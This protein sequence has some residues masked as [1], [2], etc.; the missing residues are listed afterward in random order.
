MT[1]DYIGNC[2]NAKAGVLEGDHLS[3][4]VRFGIGHLAEQVRDFSPPAAVRDLVT[5]SAA[6]SDQLAKCERVAVEDA[7]AYADAQARIARKALPALTAEV[8]KREEA[9]KAALAQLRTNMTGK[10][11]PLVAA[12]VAE[13]VSPE[14]EE[15]II[16][17]SGVV[18][19]RRAF[20]ICRDVADGKQIP[21]NLQMLRRQ[22]EAAKL[23]AP[24]A[25]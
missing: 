4:L 6:L 7:I 9:I 16:R 15:A 3:G 5:Q 14:V 21:R 22:V 2:F 1:H 12:A 8:M 10:G 17:E 20:A 25:E 11:G 19:A 13:L 23:A 24:A 18:S